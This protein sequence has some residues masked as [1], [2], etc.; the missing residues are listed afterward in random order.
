MEDDDMFVFNYSF[1][2]GFFFP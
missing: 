2:D 1:S